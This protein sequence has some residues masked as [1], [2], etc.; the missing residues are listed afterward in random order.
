[1][2]EKTAAKSVNCIFVHGWAMNSAVWEACRPLLPPWINAVFV[3]L[4]GHGSMAGINVD[5]LDGYVQALMPLSHRPVLW[6]GWSL[7]ALALI[8]LAELYP[9]RVAALFLVAA[10]PCFVQRNDWPCAVEQQ[11]FTTFAQSLEQNQ[12]KTISRFLCLQMKGVADARQQVRQLQQYMNQRGM[13]SSRAL[14]AG[15]QILIDS[16]LRQTLKQLDCSV[17]WFLGGQDVL[18]PPQLADTLHKLYRE[19]K[20]Y[21]QP[22]AG[23]APFL[24]HP[25]AF[26]RALV[27]Q[28]RRLR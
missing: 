6:V 2:T 27:E 25:R 13:A 12:E 15:L 14:T 22:E 28:A 11:T 4:P 5:D 7:G 18:I 19:H 16:D 8:R 9:E 1:M 26:T 24:S 3:D 23:H 20:I 17:S 10:T 21:F